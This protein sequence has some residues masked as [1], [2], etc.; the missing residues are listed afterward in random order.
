MSSDR[1]LRKQQQLNNLVSMVTKLSKPGDVIV[2]FC[3]GGGHVGIVLAHM[4]PSCQ[5]VLIENKELSLVR[6]KDRSD[7]LGLHNIWFIQANL[8]Y[9]KGTFNIG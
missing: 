9:F 1:A 7:E 3:S 8:D 2:D 6:A 4:L 5:V